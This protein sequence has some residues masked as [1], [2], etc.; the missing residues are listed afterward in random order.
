MLHQDRQPPA[1]HTPDRRCTAHVHLNTHHGR[2]LLHLLLLQRLLDEQL[3]LLL[4]RQVL[5]PPEA[6]HQQLAHPEAHK[7]CDG[8]STKAKRLGAP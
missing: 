2:Q 5:R 7:G 3:L 8:S 4:R 1:R 6:A